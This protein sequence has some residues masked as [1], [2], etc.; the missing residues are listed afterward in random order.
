VETP[1]LSEPP[2]PEIRLGALAS[3][4]PEERMV[5]VE[6]RHTQKLEAVGQ[7]AAGVAHEINTPIQFVTDSV[8]FL[9][10]AFADLVDY[11]DGRRSAE[12]VELGYLREHI[13]QAI[14]RTIEGLDRVA[15]IVGVLK[16]FSHPERAEKLPVNVNRLV[17]NALLLARS[18]YKYVAQVQ[19]E[20]Q[21]L[22]P[23]SCRAG[24]ISQVL[25]NLLVNA[26]HAIADRAERS[27]EGRI[28][29][30]TRAKGDVALIEIED[31][32]GGIPVAVRSRIFDPFFTTKEVGRGTGQGLAI[33]RS[34]IVGGHGGTLTFR[35]EVGSGTIFVVELPFQEK[36]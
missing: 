12:E 22:P 34:I 10:E 27:E 11:M 23:L 16:E 4:S 9:R 31:N 18:E 19:T 26:G 6:A 3:L 7:L 36:S 5:E 21:D 17:G 24:D 13:P 1:F 28:V 2:E 14:G 33:S 29:V 30:R 15:G 35:T 25:L 8:E 20:L 32:G